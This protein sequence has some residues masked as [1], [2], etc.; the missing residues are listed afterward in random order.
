MA[1]ALPPLSHHTKYLKTFLK[2][3]LA[4]TIGEIPCA[5]LAPNQHESPAYITQQA[6]VSI[7]YQVPTV[8]MMNDLYLRGCNATMCLYHTMHSETI[9]KRFSDTQKAAVCGWCNVRS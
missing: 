9:Y 5:P 8:D 7:L 6:V 4:T 3:P 2:T 1:Y